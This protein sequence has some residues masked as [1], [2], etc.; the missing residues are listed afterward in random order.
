VAGGPPG[1][2]A[3]MTDQDH[4]RDVYRSYEE[5]GRDRL[6]DMRNRGFARLSLDRDLGLREL[7]ARSLPA[8]QAALLDVGCGNGAL[9]ATVARRWPDVSLAGLDLQP[10]RITEARVNAPD[11]QFVVGS[12]D[13]LPFGDDA[14]DV[15]TA[16]TLMSSLP[17]DEMERDAAREIARVTRPG[18]WLV[19]FDLRYDNPWNAAVHGID[20]KRL[21]T[22]FPGWPQELRST[23]VLPPL[24][25]RLGRSTPVLYPILQ[26]IPPLRSHLIGRLRCPS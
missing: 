12:A 19:W 24:A 2:V 4:I 11:A 3:Q 23:T 16:I 14:F 7:L 10:E 9:L 18:G 15:V 26:L 22:L 20:A 21:A 25:R 13:A 5:R 8:G 17:S 1:S 6:W